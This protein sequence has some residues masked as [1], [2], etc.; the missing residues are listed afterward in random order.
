MLYSLAHFLR[1]HCSWIW[2]IFEFIN[3]CF[4]RLRYAHNLSIVTSENVVPLTVGYV[5]KL[6]QFFKRQPE[7]AFTY[8]RPHAFDAKTLRGL[9]KNKAFLA[10]IV[11]DDSNEIIGY[12]FL[13]CFW[14]GKCYRGYMTDYAHRRQGINRLMGIEA[15]KIAQH[16][17][18]RMF[19]SIAPD[20]VASMKSAQTVNDI[21]IIETLRNGDYLVEY[22]PKS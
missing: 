16:L 3:A 11:V 17:H 22:L 18:L 5:E 15:T 8:F 12:F 21:K 2:T 7:E 9:A 13:R 4:F 19:G 14:W 1:A 6:V 20:N 10:Y